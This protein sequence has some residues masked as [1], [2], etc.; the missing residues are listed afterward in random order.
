MKKYK[1]M[2]ILLVVL[3]VFVGLYFVMQGISKKQSEKELEEDILVTNMQ[4]LVKLQYT[5]GKTTMS[6]VKEE[7]IWYVEADKEYA[8]DSAKV[9]E[10]EEMLVD[11]MADRELKGADEPAAYGLET[12]AYT[13]TMKDVNGKETTLYI[14]NE[15]EANYYAT[16]DDKKVIYTIGSTVADALEFDL[17]AL[18]ATKEESTEVTE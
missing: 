17:T 7:D 1:S 14:G 11:V 6:F 2:I 4:E 5:D 10:I 3:V 12:P 8:L 13:I 16:T 15:V 18:E 9:D